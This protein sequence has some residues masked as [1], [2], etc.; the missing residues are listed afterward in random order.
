MIT[1]ISKIQVIALDGDNEVECGQVDYETG[2]NVYE[3]ECDLAVADQ[4]R[5]ELSSMVL[6]LC[7]VE[8][9]GKNTKKKWNNVLHVLL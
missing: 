2:K 6:T 8:V 5:I 3:I 1:P 7:E 4:I 9:Y